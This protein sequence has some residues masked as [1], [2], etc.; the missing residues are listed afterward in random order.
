VDVGRSHGCCWPHLKRKHIAGPFP[1]RLGKLEFLVKRLLGM[2]L[3]FQ[4]RLLGIQF[5]FFF[6]LLGIFVF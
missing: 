2:F 3:V 6:G 5:L 1:R 4:Q